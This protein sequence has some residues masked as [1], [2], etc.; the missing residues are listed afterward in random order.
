LLGALGLTIF[1]H[2]RV[3]AVVLVTSAAL[4]STVAADLLQRSR[5]RIRVPY[6]RA[7]L[8]EHSSR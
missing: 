7:L 2:G 1:G 5:W 6:L 4:A 3:L 8:A